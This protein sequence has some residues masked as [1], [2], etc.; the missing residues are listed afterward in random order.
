MVSSKMNLSKTLALSKSDLIVGLT[1]LLVLFVSVFG[2]RQIRLSSDKAIKFDGQTQLT[3][4]KTTNIDELNS[5][6]DSLSIEYD[7]EEL[8]W[9]SKML[10][11]KSFRKGSYLLEGDYSYELFLSKLARGIQDPIHIVVLPGISIAKFSESISSRLEISNDDIVSVFQDTVFLKELNLSKEELF[12][13]MLPETYLVYWTSSPKDLVRRVLREFEEKVSKK[14]SESIENK[15]LSISQILAMASIVEWEANIEDEK[16]TVSGLYWNRFNKR[17]LLQADPTV[18]FAL[19]ERRRLLFEDYKFE[20]PYNTYINKG[21]PPG[22]ITNP[23]LT[24]IEAS[25]FPEQHNYLY[26][27]ANPE[28]GH[29]FTRTFA[30]HQIESEKWRKWLRQ[31]YRIKRQREAEES[32]NK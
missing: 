9:S 25:I 5:L 24:T 2:S 14:Y 8:N 23:S 7:F 27:V 28:G 18:N 32:L 31:Q 13:R 21:L 6:L 1:T 4:R 15:N 3:L 22:P 19:G 30:E 11:W 26:M 29:V 17:M 20:H 12:G 16:A 10:G